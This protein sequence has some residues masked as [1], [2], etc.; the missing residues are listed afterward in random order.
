MYQILYRRSAQKGH[1]DEDLAAYQLQVQAMKG[2][3]RACWDGR[4]RAVAQFG[5]VELNRLRSD[6]LVLWGEKDRL[7]RRREPDDSGAI[8]GCRRLVIRDAGHA[9]FFD[10]TERFLDALMGFLVRPVG[11]R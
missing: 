5:V 10:Q 4:G 8:P 11:D 1:Y 6:T 7:F 9:V 2:G 3:G